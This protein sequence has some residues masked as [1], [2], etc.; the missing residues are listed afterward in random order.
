MLSLDFFENN[1]L[2]MLIAI[3]DRHNL[4]SRCIGNDPWNFEPRFCQMLDPMNF[5]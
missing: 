1:S 5:S 4:V 3:G 2:K